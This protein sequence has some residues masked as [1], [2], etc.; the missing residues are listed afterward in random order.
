MKGEPR[1]LGS[2][3]FHIS[4]LAIGRGGKRLASSIH[5]AI[6]PGERIGI[7]G[8]NGVGKTTLVRTLLGLES[9]ISGDIA[10]RGVDVTR[11]FP[12]KARQAIGYLPQSIAMVPELT[13]SDFYS[14]TWRA[15]CRGN[16]A[17]KNT[18]VDGA[19]EQV[20]L[21]DKRYVTLSHLSGGELRRALFG[22]L[23]IIKS[24]CCILDEPTAALDP[25]AEEEM[26][27]IL[28]RLEGP[29]FH[30]GLVISHDKKF[31]YSTC[32]RVFELTPTGLVATEC[33]PIQSTDGVSR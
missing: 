7:F 29:V 5:L 11:G 12:A 9:P 17:V 13:L 21:L 15:R 3:C 25:R 4:N 30:S 20:R 27:D 19:L 1:V 31:L 10:F 33:T 28:L 8:S 2:E 18:T 22:A 26:K 24:E 16:L 6:A 23:L 32:Q 14:A